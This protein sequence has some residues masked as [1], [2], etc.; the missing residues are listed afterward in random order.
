M[1]L[2]PTLSLLSDPFAE[3]LKPVLSRLSH[4]IDLHKILITFIYISDA[5]TYLLGKGCA[6]DMKDSA[7]CTPLYH[8]VFSHQTDVVTLLI[9]GNV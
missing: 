8:A 7:G 1:S 4:L 6:I 5:V 9:K 2:R 3:G